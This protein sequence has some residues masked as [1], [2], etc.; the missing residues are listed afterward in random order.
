MRMVMFFYVSRISKTAGCGYHT[1]N[2]LTHLINNNRFNIV[3]MSYWPAYPYDIIVRA[4]SY[5]E[6]LFFNKYK[7]PDSIVLTF[8]VIVRLLVSFSVII[9]AKKK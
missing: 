6:R 3:E 1:F 9:V 5:L 4:A 7:I 2:E 8:K